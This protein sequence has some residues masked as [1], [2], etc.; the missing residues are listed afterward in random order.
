M[1][2]LCKAKVLVKLDNCSLNLRT[3]LGCLIKK[4]FDESFEHLGVLGFDF[5]GEIEVSLL[6][7]LF[8]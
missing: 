2:I 1:T 4:A 5:D 3:K 7:C 6:D 8:D